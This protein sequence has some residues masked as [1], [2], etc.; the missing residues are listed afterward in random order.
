MNLG[1]VGVWWS[2]SWSAESDPSLD[3]AREME[4]LGYGTIWSSGGFNAGLSSRFGRILSSTSRIAVASGIV[5]IWKA[6]P[7]DIAEAVTA[8]EALHPERFLLGLGASHGP[9]IPEYKRP[10]S[11]MVEYLDALDDIAPSVPKERRVLAALGSRML[12][13]AAERA[14]GAHPYF[15]P[16]EHTAFARR[17]M[18]DGP[19]LAPE[20]TVVLE[21]DPERARTLARTFTALYL[22]LP[23][24]TDNLRRLGFGEDDVA[25]AGSARLVDAVVAWGDPEAIASRV[26]EH[27]EAGADHVCLQVVGGGS[28]FP[29]EE[30]RQLAAVLL[31]G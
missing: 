2:G 27:Y 8:L 6:T 7:A 4:A 21:T 16:V 13:L 15:V 18:G 1:R 11:T 17:V 28:G 22:T 23:N 19:L 24:Y 26:R 31:G 20:L 12:E 5:N 3:V 14:V 25:G 9:V 30:Y 10:Y 29:L